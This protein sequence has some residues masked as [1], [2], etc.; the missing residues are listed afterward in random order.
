MCIRDRFIA[1][2]I[3]NAEIPDSQ[4]AYLLDEASQTGSNLEVELS[5]FQDYPEEVQTLVMELCVL[6]K[7][8]G[9]VHPAQRRYLMEIIETLE[10]DKKEMEELL[11]L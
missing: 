5:L 1:P 10:F 2:V 3:E 11:A 4:K 6:A 7:R 8:D 9:T